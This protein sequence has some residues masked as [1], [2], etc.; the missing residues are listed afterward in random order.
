MGTAAPGEGGA[1]RRRRL[2][3]RTGKWHRKKLNKIRNPTELKGKMVIYFIHLF[4]M[5]P[6]KV[7]EIARTTKKKL[8]FS[9][10]YR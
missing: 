1:R 3:L 2:E 6:G 5:L 9:G 7:D 10:A 4:D 8:F